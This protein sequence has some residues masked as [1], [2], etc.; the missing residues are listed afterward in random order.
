[1]LNVFQKIKEGGTLSKDDVLTL[2]E[3]ENF[4]S[5]YFELLKISNRRSQ[6]TF[7]RKGYLFAQIG[8]NA[9]PCNG[10]CKFCSLSADN[11]IMTSKS[12][13]TIDEIKKEVLKI[14]FKKVCTLFLMSTANYDQDKFIEVVK[15][16]KEIIPDDKELVAN[17]GDFDY[18]YACK[19]KEAGI[20]GVYHIVRL[21]EGIDTGLSI[22]QRIE[23]LE[24]IKRAELKLYYCVEP[25]GKEHTS[26]ELYVEMERARNYGVDI[27][28]VMR[29]VNINEKDFAAQTEIDEYQF[30][31]IAAV[32]NLYVQPKVSMN[33][34]EP[35]KVAMMAGINQ[36]YVEIGINPRDNIL[37]TAGNRGYSE[38]EAEKLL[39]NLGYTL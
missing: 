4:S 39:L 10:R 38:I 25:I 1:M 2:L 36:L 5:D 20:T 3:I 18:N 35:S 9:M 28:A 14:D 11:Y 32:A 26:E 6:D 27:M 33:V 23:T 12:E 7:N 29:R 34:H 37:E 30:A 22:E 16:V 17:I 21:R 24:A 13:K 15:A 31:K 8:I 19:L